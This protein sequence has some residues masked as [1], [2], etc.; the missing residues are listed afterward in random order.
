MT[1][2]LHDDHG[3]VQRHCQ[4]L[5]EARPHGWNNAGRIHN[6]QYTVCLAVAFACFFAEPFNAHAGWNATIRVR[7]EQHIF[8]SIENTLDGLLNVR[9]VV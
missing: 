2:H 1:T 9:G 3:V 8:A 5:R 4:V 7:H 6:P